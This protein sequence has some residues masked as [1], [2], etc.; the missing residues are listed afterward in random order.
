MSMCEALSDRMPGV[1]AGRGEWTAREQD[2]LAS[3]S[4]CAAE[5]KLVVAASRL[6]QRVTVNAPAITP[7]VLERV[8]AAKREEQRSRFVKRA[9]VLGSL[10]VAATMLLVMQPWKRQVAPPVEIVAVPAGDLQLAELDDASPAELELVLVEFDG[11][12]VPA[13]GLDGPDLEDLDQSTVER[14]LHSWEE[15]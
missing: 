10:A 11:P 7:R 3:C 9:G 15:S 8:R 13:S 6:G 5:W 1:A 12:V 14:A 2:H 4:D